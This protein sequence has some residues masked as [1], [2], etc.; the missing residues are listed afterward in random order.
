M[1]PEMHNT[2]TYG[3]KFPPAI[4][5]GKSLIG[6]ARA[7]ASEPDADPLGRDGRLR[8]RAQRGVFSLLKQAR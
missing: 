8:S 4:K 6:L 5:Y 1:L 2:V 3:S 7:A